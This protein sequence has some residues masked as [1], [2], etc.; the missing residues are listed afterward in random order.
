MTGDD[1][2]AT[3]TPDASPSLEGVRVRPTGVHVSTI[4]TSGEH[5]VDPAGTFGLDARGTLENHACERRTCDIRHVLEGATLDSRT[6]ELPPGGR[7]TV[8]F[9]TEITRADGDGPHGIAVDRSRHQVPLRLWWGP[10]P[11]AN[12]VWL[13][14]V[15][16]LRVESGGDRVVVGARATN[17]VEFYSGVPS[18]VALLVDGRRERRTDVELGTETPVPFDLPAERVAG[19][20][21]VGVAVG[22]ARRTAQYTVRA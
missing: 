3:S 19:T 7:R 22:M 6:I 16:D 11:T 9:R 14:T 5:E 12:P 4:A 21:S 1:P 17:R 20:H 10:R 18:P 15:D 2:T 13:R 8:T